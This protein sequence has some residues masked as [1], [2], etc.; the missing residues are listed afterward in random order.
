MTPRLVPVRSRFAPVRS[1]LAPVWS[2]LGA[3]RSRLLL[4]RPH[5]ASRRSRLVPVR[6]LPPLWPLYLAVAAASMAGAAQVPPSL[7]ADR[8]VAAVLEARVTSGFRARAKLTVQ[9]APP[10]AQSS[11][12]TACG[13]PNKL[14]RSLAGTN[15]EISRQL[16]ITGRRD[17]QHTTVV[18]RVL[19][20]KGLVLPASDFTVAS[21]AASLRKSE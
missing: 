5:L 9:P 11:C 18:Y 6:S 4:V 14:T 8:L 20:A 17:G 15:E 3:D 16:L 13:G 7:S 2:H 1:R 21:V 12:P 19:S 10:S